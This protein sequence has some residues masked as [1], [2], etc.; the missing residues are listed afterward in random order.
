MAMENLK[1]EIARFLCADEDQILCLRGAW[2][3]GKTYLWNQ[4]LKKARDQNKLKP[5]MYSYVSLFG[6]N[7]LAE[8]RMS[9]FQNMV[10]GEK[11]GEAPT[12]LTL[13]RNIVTITKSLGRISAFMSNLPFVSKYAG[14]SLV[15]LNRALASFS[16]RNAIICLDDLERR[17]A[18]LSVKDVMGLMS[19]LRANN[20]CKVVLI[21][22]DK[23]LSSEEEKDFKLYY[24][25][26]VD[27]S[28]RCAPTA[29]ESA[30]IALG[31][32]EPIS[33]LISAC[34]L[35]LGITNIRVIRKLEWVVLRTNVY[36]VGCHAKVL[37]QATRTLILLGWCLYAPQDAPNTEFVM[38]LDV[39]RSSSM[40]DQ[41]T[42]KEVAWIALLDKY[43]FRGA[44][45]FDK[46]LFQCLESGIFDQGVI[47]G[48]ARRESENVEQRERLNSLHRAFGLFRDSFDDNSLEIV[49]SLYTS[50]CEVL[51]D[52]SILDLNSTVVLLKELGAKDKAAVLIQSY[53]E[54]H[55]LDRAS[56]DLS[57]HPFADR[58]SEEDILAAFYKRQN[59]FRDRT[60]TEVLEKMANSQSWN[61]EEIG[62]VASMPVKWFIG[63]FKGCKGNL[64]KA[65]IDACLQ[66]DRIQNRSFA[67]NEIARRATSALKQIAKES[68]LNKIRVLRYGINPD[69]ESPNGVE[70]QPES[71]C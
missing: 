13:Q 59:L 24:E 11:V 52:V 39:Y 57:Q 23:E 48:P 50:F 12:I 4:T 18:A 25:K 5:R 67:S 8:L 6:L 30:A 70:E 2:G 26:T 31:C 62:I 1:A 69:Y 53:M 51:R 54:L 49:D 37:E 22:N 64:L 17:G 35:L 45:D 46:A 36:L 43:G 55:V 66:F 10:E 71:T 14:S 61:D 33:G 58:I 9:I 42:S 29:R 16:T 44:D 19:G 63:V 60:A 28:L 34:T 32:T 3:V 40:P 7:G 41:R 20:A 38:T 68:N 15:G 27:I 47:E 65:Q 56:A 21:L